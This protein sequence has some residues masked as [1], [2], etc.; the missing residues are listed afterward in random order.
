MKVFLLYDLG[1]NIPFISDSLKGR[2]ELDWLGYKCESTFTNWV[3]GAFKAMANT[4]KEDIIV[5]WYDFQAI[6]CYWLCKLTLRRRRIVGI[7]LLLKD[8]ETL[9]NKIVAWLYKKTL[10]SKYF[11]ASV[12]SKEYGLHLKR[13]L[14]IKKDFFLLH[15]VFHDSYRYDKKV[16]VAPNTVFVGG[17]NGRDWR[18]MLEVAKVMPNVQFRL[19]MPETIFQDLKNDLPSNVIVKYNLSMDDFMREMCASKIVALPLDTEA[20]A[21]LIVMFQAVANK[22]YIITTDTMTTREYVSKDRGSLVSNDIR[23]WKNA[24]EKALHDSEADKQA[25]NFYAYLRESCS[26]TVFVDGIE[27]MLE[28]L[29]A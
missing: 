22:K 11:V 4:E 18:F 13:R 27:I 12:T 9:E 10:N 24:I 20:P 6:L 2:Y 3:K 29:N 7:N 21:G 8:K 25:N 15:D 16:D 28:T 17:R 19:V 5:C 14:G 1:G 26:E 23:L